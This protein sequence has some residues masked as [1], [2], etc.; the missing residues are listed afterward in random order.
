[1]KRILFILPALLCFA[2]LGNAQ[3]LN[4]ISTGQTGTSGTNWSTS[5]SN[6]VTIT[7]TGDANIHPD[8][9]SGYLNSGTSVIVQILTAT[10]GFLDQRDVINKTAGGDA[11]LTLRANRR[12]MANNAITSTSGKLNVVIWSDYNNTNDGGSSITG[13]ITTNGGHV[14][15]GGSSSNAGSATWNGLTVGN[16][17]S[18]G[19]TGANAFAFD[20]SGNVTTGGGDILIWTG[21]GVDGD[22]T[23]NGIGIKNNPHLNA[24]SGN[25]SLIA[26]KFQNWDS[27]NSTLQVSSTGTFTLA[28][29]SDAPWSSTFTWSTSTS[30]SNVTTSVLGQPLQI[31]NF[32]SLGGFQLGSYQG[33]GSAF[34]YINTSDITF[35]SSTTVSGPITAYGGNIAANQNITSTLSGAA[36]L[37]Q[38]TGTIDLASSKKVESNAGN[39]TFKSNSGGTASSSAAITLSSG[40]SV[41]SKGGNITL[42]G[43]STGAQGAGLYA[44]STQ[45]GILIES[46]TLSAAGGNIKLYGKNTTNYNNGIL[47]L[48]TINTTG[49]GTISL[50]G[51]AR[52]GYNSTSVEY[53][54]GV[55]FGVSSSSTIETENGT[56]TISGLL[57]EAQSTT[58]GAINFYR[59]SGGSGLAQNIISKTGAI[60][61]TG[62]VGATGANSFTLPSSGNVFFGS[63]SSGAWTATGNIVFNFDK[64]NSSAT[65]AF[66]VKSTGAVTYQPVGNSFAEAMTFP[67][68]SAYVIAESAS[69]LTIGK[70]SNTANITMAAATSVAGPITVYGG[71]IFA[72][73]NLT[74]TLSGTAILLQATGYINVSASRT[75][76]SNNGDITFRA[77]AGGTANTTTS[78]ITL[79]SGSSLLSKGGNIT[80][81]GNFTGTQG[82]GLYAASAKVG[83]S[84]AILISN[85]T[86]SA[87]GGNINIYGRCSTSYDDGIRLQANISTTGAGI[88]G[89]YG[90]AFGGNNGTEYFGG[91][92]FFNE[93]SRIEA[94]NGNVTL[95]GILTNSQSAEGYGI[96]FY[97]SGGAMGQTKHIQ[98]L[99]RT[100]NI[101]ITGDRG[102]S[103]G[104][105]IGHSSH[106]N[107]YF[108]SPSD[109]SYTASGD[110]KFT[111]SSLINAGYNGFK[112]K[113]TGDVTYEPVKASF[114]LAQIFPA[115]ANY[116]LAESASSLTIGKATNTA[117]ITMDA[118]TSVAGPITVFGGTIAVNENLNTTTGAALGDVLLKASGD[119]TLAGSKSIIT[120]GGDVILWS[121]S[122][123]TNG[124]TISLLSSASVQTGG[125]KIVLAGGADD[126]SNSG[127]SNDGIPDG[128][129]RG[130]GVA[131]ISTT[132]SFTLNSGAGNIVLRGSSNT[133]DGVLLSAST[134]G[135]ITTTG[136][137][138]D[139]NGF[140]DA[141]TVT[142]GQ[143]QSGIRTI[144]GGVITLDSGTGLINLVGNGPRHG[145]G[146]GITDAVA[147]DAATQTVIKSTNTTAN[148]IKIKGTV[149]AGGHG[150]SF[151][152]AS[153]KLHATG[154]L[155][156][157]TVDA[158]AVAWSTTIYSPIE[159][160]AVSGPINWLNSDATDGIYTQ[161]TSVSIALG[162]KAGVTG[163]TSSS[164]DINF[165]LKK[166]EG[167]PALAFGTTGKVKI[168]GV[169]GTASFGQAFNSS[170]FGLNANSQTMSG[171]TFGSPNNTQNLTF[172][173]AL[174]V[175]GPITAY[176]GL[177]AVD[178]NLN[179]T[180]GTTSGDILLKS[181]G[182]IA[183]A[184]SKSITTAGGDVILWSNSDNAA[185][186]GSI[187]LRNGS[188]ITTGSGTVAGGH[189]WL[190][191]GSDG[192]T[193]NGLAVG[194]GY[195]VPGT[196]FV[197]SNGGG[198]INGGIYLEGSS[199]NSFGGHVKLAGDA[200][201]STYGILA[202]STNS[203][204]SK[205]GKIDLDGNA[206]NAVSASSTGILFGIHDLSIAST[207]NLT[208]SASDVAI[209]ISGVGRGT[210][211]AVA[212]SGTL[213]VLS[214][215][216]GEISINGNAIGTGRSIVAGNYYSG[217]LNAFANSGKITLNGGTKAVQ[218]A[219]QEFAGKTSGPSKINIGQ[220]GEI[221]SSSSD[222]FITADNIA[223]AASGIAVNS[224]GK[225]T[226]ESSSN[227]FANALTFPIANLSLANTVS[228]LT[229]GK[230]TNTQNITIGG[231]TTIAGPITAYG[232]TIALN[233]NLTSTA[234]T[235]TGVSLDGQRIIQNVGIAVTTSGANIDYLASGFST[236]S[237]V[238]N[239]IKIGDVSGARAS[240]NAGGGNVSLTGSFGT[241]ST[242][243]QDD[244]GIYLFSTDVITSGTGSI[245]L[246]GDATNTLTTTTAYGMSMGNATLKTASG[247][248][249]LNGTGGK[250][251]NNSR[252]IVADQSSNKIVSASG[253]I[254]L[255]EI[256]PTG[257]T[258]TYTGFFM[259]PVSTANSFIGADGTE[260]SSS[261][262]SVTIKGDK[263]FFDV[264]ST[265]RNNINTSGAIVFESV[266]NS[267]ETA[268]SLTGLTISGNPSSVRVGKT[269]NTANITLGSAV[270]AAG[271]IEVYGGT[272]AVNAALTATNSNI[273]L[274]ASTAATQTAAIT[275]KGLALNGAGTFTLNNDANNI[276]TIAGGSAAAKIGSLSFV[277][278]SGGLEIGTVNP[279]GITATGPIKIETLEGNITLSENITTDDTSADA[280]ILNAGKNAAIGTATGGDII[281]SGNP[282]I[283]MG[284]GGIAKLFSGSDGA[285]TGL[286]T[287]VG[288]AN[289]RESVDET[290]AAFTP[291]LTSNNKYALYRQGDAGL[292]GL[293]I[294]NSGGAALNSG[295][296]FSNN[297]IKPTSG[298]AVSINASEINNYLASGPLTIRAGSITF[299]ANINSTTANS[300]SVLSNTFINNS[301][302]TSIT[303]QDGDVL[304]AT[305]VDDAT[306][307]ESTTN[308]TA[309][310]R[311][312]LT[313]TTNG[314]DITIGGENITGTG[315]ALGSS[316]EHYTEGIRIDGTVNINSSGGNIVMRGKSYARAV[317]ELYGASGLGFYF[318]NSAGNINSGSG[319]INLDGY[320]QT[321]GSSYSSGIIVFTNNAAF[322][323]T[324]QSANQ[325]AD[326]I[327][328]SGKATGTTGEAFG[329]ETEPT[330]I[331]NVL[332]T[333]TGG[334]I[335]LNTGN[336]IA[337]GNE[338]VFRGTT[339]IL[340]KSGPI[341]ILG[342]Q[343]GAASTGII[344][345]ES[346]L[347]LGS[348]AVTSI[349]TSTSNV[350][351]QF[352][353][354]QW[355]IANGIRPFIG[356]TGAFEL[357]SLGTS[358]SQGVSSSFFKYGENNQLLSGLTIGRTTNTANITFDEALTVAGPVNGNGGTV[359]V[360]SNLTSTLAAA[361]ILM[362]ATAGISTAANVNITTNKGDLILWSDSDNTSGGAISIGDNNVINTTN[363]LTTS[364]LTGGGKIVLAG[365]LDNGANEGTAN[366][367]IPDGFA[368]NSTN[369]GINL[370]TTKSN[371][372][373]MYSGGGDIIVRANSTASGTVTAVGLFQWG[374]WLAN[375]GQGAIDI[376]G[377]AVSFY[378][379]NFTE[380]VSNVTTGDMHLQL[381]SA[382]TSGTAISINGTST[383]LYG[384]VFNYNN[385]KEI[386]ATGG[387]DIIVN[388]TGGGIYQGIFLQ[389]QDILASAGAITMNAG[390]TG[391]SFN[392]A[393]TRIGSKTGSTIASSTANVKF[394]ANA[395]SPNV[396]SVNTTGTFTFEPFGDSFT[397]ALTYPISNITLGNTISG[398]TLGKASNTANITFGSATTIAGPITA[399]GGDLTVSSALT[400]TGTNAPILLK[401]T[402]HNIV[403][404]SITSNG[405]DIT[406]WSDSENNGTGG[407]RVNDNVS[408][409]SR[410]STDRTASTNTT[411]G[412]KITLAGGLDDA[413]IASGLSTLTSGLVA[414]DGYPDGYAVNSGSTVTETGIALGTSTS[415]TGHNAN[416]NMLS[417]GGNIRLHALVTKINTNSG[418]TGLLAFHGVN[419]NAGTTGDVVMIG[420]S[421]AGT[422][423][424]GMD[425]AAWRE[426]SYT[427]SS[428]VRT[429]NGNIS[430]IGRASNG[431]SENI[432][433]AI[434]GDG[435]KRNIFAATGSGNIT[436]NGLATGAGARDIRMT[437]SDV[438]S[439]SGTITLN[440][441]GTSGIAFGGYNIGDGLFIGQKAG[442]LVTTS[443]SNITL[444]SN[445][446]VRNKPITINTSGNLIYEPFGT[447]FSSAVN[448]PLTSFTLG[449]VGGIT[450]GKPGN[451]SDINIASLVPTSR[452]TRFFGANLAL[453]G[454][455]D[456]PNSNLVLDASSTLTQTQSLKV[457]GLGL[458][459]TGSA[460]LTNPGN[461]IG[462]IAGGSAAVPTGA[463][464]L[465][466]NGQLSVGSVNPTGITSSGLIELE[467]LSGDLL[468]T[469]PIV[470]TL[471]TGDAVRLYA[472]KDAAVGAAGDGNIKI[473]GNG[474]VTIESG[475]RAL[476][477]SGSVA[478]STGLSDLVTEANMRTNVAA[479]TAEA[480]ITPAITSTGKYALYR[481]ANLA[482]LGG[483]TIVASGGSNENAGWSYSAGTIKPTSGTAVSINASA[484]VAK[485]GSANLTVEG[486]SIDINANVV[487][488]TANSLTFTANKITQNEGISV[489]TQAGNINYTITNGAF[490][491]GTD[492]ILKLGT[493]VTSPR[494]II[495]ANGGNVTI[496]SAFGSTGVA[497]GTDRAIMIYNTDILTTG[498]GTISILGDATNNTTTGNNWGIQM[499]NPRIQTQLG[500]ITLT[501]I[502]GKAGS[503]RGIAVDSYS[504]K[505][506]SLS[507]DI[508]INDLKPV[509]STGTY[510]GLY[511]G[512]TTSNLIYFG[513]DGT[514]VISSTSKITINAEKLGL[515][516]NRFRTT[517]DFII[518]SSGDSFEGNIDLGSTNLFSSN[519]SFV[520]IGKTTNTA[521]VTIGTA[522]SV[523][524]PISIYGGTLAINAALT[525]TNSNII[526]GATTAITQTAALTANGLALTGSGSATLTN[527][528]NSINTI[529]GGSSSAKIG[530]L[531]YLN[532]KAFTVGSVN[533]TG[534]YSTGLIE[535]ATSTGDLLIT[536]PIVSTLA[537]GDAVKL[538]ADKDAAAGAAGDGNIIISGNG[539]VTIESGARAL[540][541]SGSAASST[542]L[543]TLV[544]EANTRTNVDATTAEAMIA[545]AITSTGKYALYREASAQLDNA[546]L[547]SL[548]VGA[549]T[550]SPV[551]ETNETD[552][553]VLLPAGTTSFSFTPTLSEGT[554]SIKINGTTHT[555]G[556]AFTN[557]IAGQSK[558]FTIQVTSGDN[559]VVKT[560][561]V[562]VVVPSATDALAVVGQSITEDAGYVRFIVTGKAAQKVSLE[563]ANITAKGLGIDYGA[564]ATA[565]SLG[566]ANLEVSIDLGATWTVFNNFTTIPASKLLWV[567]TPLNDDS[568]IESE[569]KF[570]LI[571]SPVSDA[572]EGMEVYDIGY[573]LVNLNFPTTTISGTAKTV[574]AVYRQ[575]NAVT[576]G[577]QALDAHMKILGITNVTSSTYVVDNNGSNV[578]RFQSELNA[579]VSAGSYIEYELKFYKSGTTTQVGV[580]NFFVTA[581]DVDGKEYIE[582]NNF[583]SYQVGTG[584][585]LTISNPR[586]GFTRYTGATTSLSGIAFDETASFILNYTNPIASLVFRK[587]NSVAS[588]TARLFSMA[589]GNSIGNFSSS[590]S[591]ESTSSVSAEGVIIDNDFPAPTQLTI[592]APQLT[593]VKDYSGT[594]TAVVVPG[595]I[596]GIKT[597]DVVTLNAT[598]TYETVA[599]GTAKKI[600]VVYTLSGADAGDYLAPVNF[601]VN[602][603]VIN[604]LNIIVTPTSG[605]TK[606]YGAADPTLTYTHTGALTGETAA[607][608]GT[609][610]RVTGNNVGDYEILIGS[611]ALVDNGSFKT[612]NYTLSL[613]EDVMMSITKAT[614][615]VT[616]KDDSKFVSTADLSGY[617]GI[618]YSGFV[619]GET[620]SVVNET[621]L[622]FSRTNSG[623][624]APGD[625]A[626]VLNASGLV[627]SNYSFN[628][629]KG[630]YT[631][632]A[633]DQLLVKIK[634]QEVVYGQAVLY[635]IAS[636]KY[637]SSAE[638]EI[639]DLT[640]NAS[641]NN[642]KITIT[643]GAGGVAKFDL[644]AISP[645]YSSS[646]RLEVGSYVLGATNIV[647]TSVNFNE[648]IVVQGNLTITPLE[649]FASVKEGLSKV[650]DGTSQM[651]DLELAL[652]TPY[653]GDFVTVSGIGTFGNQNVGVQTYSIGQMSLSGDDALNYYV[654]GG[655]SA[656]LSGTNGEITKRAIV[657]TPESDQG[658]IYAAID[659]VLLYDYSGNVAGQIPS[660]SGLL[661]REVGE[662][663][664]MYEIEPGSI[665]LVDNGT[666]LA[667]N[668]EIVFIEEKLFNIN[669]KS[670]SSNDITVSPVP[671]QIYNGE[672]QMPKPVV[673]DGTDVLT[674][675]QDYTLSYSE[676]IEAGTATITITGI[677]DYSGTRTVTFKISPAELLVTPD[678]GLTKVYGSVDPVL[679][680]TFS[681]NI[682]GQ[683][684]AFGGALTRETGQDVSMY[685]I[686]QGSLVLLDNASFKASNYKLVVS[687]GVDMEISKATIT[688]TVNND[689]KF[690]TR[691]DVT[692]F[693]GVN[694][695][696][697][698]FGETASVIDVSALEITRSNA[699]IE[700]AG[701]YE[702]VLIGSGLSSTNYTFN[703]LPGDFV[704]VAA[705]QLLVK[706]QDISVVYGQLINYQVASAEYLSS[707]S[708]S[709]VNLTANSTVYDGKVTITDGVGGK[710]LFDLAVLEPN[711]S[712]TSR[713]EVGAYK[714]DATNI[715]ETSPNFSN[716]IVVQGSLSITPK[717]LVASVVDG[718]TKE[719]DGHLQM[720]D[721][722]LD[723]ATPYEGDVLDVKAKGVFDSESVGS[724]YYTVSDMVLSGVDAVNY[725]VQG[726]ATA[727]LDGFNAEITRRK[728]VLTP[729]SDQSKLFGASDP[730]LTY[731]YSGN[732]IGSIPRFTGVL[733]RDTGE[734]Q[735]EYDI[736]LGSISII[737]NDSFIAANYEL[738][739]TEDVVFTIRKKD[740]SSNDFTV[741]A[742]PDVIYNGQLRLP[743]PTVMD[744]LKTLVK[745]QDFK[746]FYSENKDAG[747][748]TITIAG[749]ND[750]S[751]SRTVTFLINPA[752]LT[753]VPNTGFTKIYGDSDPDFSYSYAG[754]IAGETPGF[755]G[756]LSR[757]TGE[758]AGLYELNQGSLILV[759]NAPF[760]AS[761][762]VLD[763]S[764]GVQMRITRAPL[765]VQVNSDSKFVTKA[766][767]NGY[768]G[769]SFEGFKFGED[770][771][772]LDFANLKITRINEG[773]E[774][775]STYLDVLS[776]SGIASGNYAFTY[777]P[778]DY[779][780]IAAEELR[781]K[782]ANIQTVYGEPATYSIESASYVAPDNTLVDLTSSA[783]ILNGR[784]SI[785]DGASGTATF[786]LALISPVLSTAGKLAVGSYNLGGINIT[787][788]STNFSNTIVV[789]GVHTVIPKELTVSITSSKTKV[790][791]GNSKL[792][793]LELALASPYTNDLVSV[794]GTGT[795]A[796]ANAGVQSY[797]VSG[798][799][800]SG[801][802]A[803]NYFINGGAA[804][805]VQGTNGEITKR[806]L[807]I[808]PQSNQ[809]KIYGTSDPILNFNYSGNV[810]GEIPNF[811][812]TLGRDIG[813]AQ[814]L[815]EIR[816]GTLKPLN[817]ANFQIGNY[818]VL[819]T[820]KIYF[821]ITRKNISS[822]EISLSQV[823]DRTYNGESQTPKPIIKDGDKVLVEGIDY[824]L[825][826][827]DN[828]DA[829][830][831]TIVIKGK[832][833][834][835]GERSITFEIKPKVL[836]IIPDAGLSKVYGSSDP[837]LTYTYS[838]NV[839]GE[840]P[841]FT[842]RLSRASGENADL[843]EINLGS[844]NTVDNGSF[845]IGNYLINIVSDVNMTINRANLVVKVNNDSKFI[846]KPDIKDY[847]GIRYEGFQ[848]G[849]NRSVIDETNLRITRTNEGVELAQVYE[850]VLSASGVAS[851][852]YSFTYQNGD[853]TIVGAQQLLVKIANVESTYGD[854]PT[855]AIASAEYLLSEGA[856]PDVIDLRSS[857]TVTGRKVVVT[858]GASGT[859]EFDIA[860]LDPIFSTAGKLSVR[861]Y[862]LNANN[863]TQTSPNFSNTIVLQGIHSLSPKALTASVTSLKSKVYDG[864]D[865]MPNLQLAL[866][867]PFTEDQVTVSG[868]GV[869]TSKNAGPQS[870][871]VSGMALSGD[872][873]GNYYV[874]GGASALIQGTDGLINKR[875]ITITPDSQQ[876]KIFGNLDP[877]LTFKY[878]GNLISETPK[879]GGLLGRETGESKADY[880][881]QIGT[882]T[883]ANNGSFLALNYEY[884]FTPEVLFNIDEKSIASIDITVGT[885]PSK[886]YNGLAQTP[887]PVIKDGVQTLVEG[888]DYTLSYSANIE[889]GTVTISI[890]GIGG[891]SGTRTI[892]FDITKAPLVVTADA[893]S[894][895]FGASDPA[896]TA[897]ITG[898][899][900][901]EDQTALTG[902]LGFTRVQGENVGTYTITPSGLSAANY[903]ISYETALLSILTKGLSLSD[904]TAAPIA[905]VIYKGLA[906]ELEPILKDG[907]KTL[908]KDTDYTLSYLNNINAGTASVIITA[909]GNYSGTKTIEFVIRKAPLKVIADNK[910]KIIGGIDP[911]LTVSYT[912]FVNSETISALSGTLVIAREIGEELGTYTITPSGL[913]AANYAISFEL[914]SF[915]IGD[916]VAPTVL[917]KKF[918]LYLDA[919]GKVILNAADVDNGSSDL[920][921]I[922]SMSVA[923]SEFTCA[924][925]GENTV[926]LTVK[927]KSGNE[928]SMSTTVTVVDNIAPTV[929]TRTVR[930]ALDAAG[931]ASIT[932]AQ[933]NDGSFDN[934][935]IQSITLDQT[936]FNCAHVGSQ[937]LTLTVTDVNGNVSSGTA[938]VIVENNAP[939]TD[940]DGLKNNCDEDDDNDGIS[941][942]DEIKNGTDPLNADSDGDGV[943]DGQELRDGTNPNDLCSFKIA[944]QTLT[945][946]AAW[947][948]ADCDGDGVT[949]GKERADGTSSL[950][951]CDF[952]VA[953]RTLTPSD[954]WK[955][956][957]CDGD[958]LKNEVDGIEDCDNDG[959]PNFQDSD[960]CK[961]DI[962]MANVFTPNG[963]GI[964]DEIKPVLL[965]IDRF[966][967]FKV[968]N[969]WGNL[970]F[971]TNDREK[972]WDGTFKTKGQGTETFQW[973]VEGYDRDGK[974]IRRTGMITLLR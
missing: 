915:S 633:A 101:Q 19:A 855:Y 889:T 171:F 894:K 405:G 960:T 263:A 662:N 21:R 930:I 376:N 515:A 699:S 302:A 362:K 162:S 77:N 630:D 492:W 902:T 31:N 706:I 358:F 827:T 24:G 240:I 940:R 64:L 410:T 179:T 309:Q 119:I 717:E 822:S 59:N 784:V 793:A 593:K 650:Y 432:A 576:I 919:S 399:Y 141:G 716:T 852:N 961:I 666:F 337:N 543:S 683:T 898:Y 397:N 364:N 136:G 220:G 888:I 840:I 148:A 255:N 269:T 386:L 733:V 201:T 330:S 250:A 361:P 664:G 678:S 552:Y 89:L 826:Y 29:D 496:N 524:G 714:I 863:I 788:T 146:F 732:V 931:Q 622:V 54:G 792:P 219:L 823:I 195:A 242:A 343:D 878:V 880:E 50:F 941:D 616:V 131:G 523:A 887:K 544:T 32:S 755:E 491:T 469:E 635:E 767:V 420:N 120:A 276:A 600:T 468:I 65:N 663:Q 270:T 412:G 557:N 221:T 810:N 268:P 206:S 78:A 671:D 875:I 534:I 454:A 615:T 602:D 536:E 946:N 830:T 14:W 787:K 765:V 971:E 779:T 147:S 585:S 659:P 342:G 848:F 687:E 328:I 127:T 747:I 473:S 93:V 945:P 547:A 4:I 289:V 914:G 799:V 627:A 815:Y 27:A 142:S 41:L 565:T 207:M 944:S 426:A 387:G 658:K 407:I 896:F 350:T 853:F 306:D 774:A 55:S 153:T 581:V 698:V 135:N 832:G 110:V 739:F 103:I 363:G 63:P 292:G 753:V 196:T 327:K 892:T 452:P 53:F 925:I 646:S 208:S 512:G 518:Q 493:S 697:F 905:D 874:S 400:S 161:P 775:A 811:G 794:S 511:F 619:Y 693:A 229:L 760:K 667:N 586:A 25:V 591:T 380:P 421:T 489:T 182:D 449:S 906:Y 802:D 502:G 688:V 660:F 837:E 829:G 60:T 434:D 532:N 247:T 211:D 401:A 881:I 194:S 475:A 772:A 354:F 23:R 355:D 956:G 768:A 879:F 928:S 885:I 918:I 761:N 964:N 900:N 104:R 485:L 180:T 381:I 870:Y 285:S 1:M 483:I 97:R 526:L 972:G 933:V 653:T 820:E 973:L 393:G 49:V 531:N 189:V 107:I 463:L 916:N 249:T 429:V 816:L 222:V 441:G 624:E 105:G 750:Y 217:I 359:A 786:D 579:T 897:V 6:P 264:N 246:T 728:L 448:W 38:A 550:L 262:S 150:I 231:A 234:T 373:Q 631:I 424:I 266:A 100:G 744:G 851:G 113:T 907:A 111:Y 456:I 508:T 805:L 712:T 444:I 351:V 937:T 16:G 847:A 563:M 168:Q 797:S 22:A 67:E 298:T 651:N 332:A 98:I 339:S 629:I 457:A 202:Y 954:A 882:L 527:A 558:T 952:K 237:G 632:V 598:A 533:P 574:G 548:T 377:K 121:D 568:I 44:Q 181:S 721:L 814:G 395:I 866:A 711:Y 520:Q 812:G 791:D 433:M 922:A 535:L 324:I 69:S 214:T 156:G 138:I 939:D 497:G 304:F 439:G 42:G 177:I 346:P 868:R 571:V 700:A 751:G 84:P 488:T 614:L 281:V 353:L 958:G 482:D 801:N 411:G 611:L 159:I 869:F 864:S 936:S 517:G 891:F 599:A 425:L 607:F 173:Q 259:K 943:N 465:V 271:P 577:G 720:S 225:V 644:N 769:L 546:N 48:G 727:M 241:T 510:N 942:L 158:T 516:Y 261:S 431:T 303:T 618:T 695:D 703:Y 924:N 374:K 451:L 75:I 553:A 777:L 737:D 236:T 825:I 736:N 672:A 661:S 685:E 282:T 186:N 715:I 808:T 807:L 11:T 968:Y 238:D 274:T 460:V 52:G 74:S 297:T 134:T 334:G 30:G 200:S 34:T 275:A 773:I 604:P 435:T 61:I 626:D 588:S 163:L 947:A 192:A 921:G 783:S 648:T 440:A 657:L 446:L 244:F 803:A 782:I 949:N 389:N 277:D 267:F 87:A 288:T 554:A 674:E 911:A 831:S 592:T 385:P 336:K 974:L 642:G 704:I 904:I 610:A 886:V 406:L 474:T 582:L 764:S 191:G 404:A 901:S 167:T 272:I 419:M 776:A 647:E 307:N 842:G 216:A 95:E 551:F 640:A 856:N 12:A 560:Y 844:L 176:G 394:I 735:G 197:P 955:N 365:G 909:K 174:T 513:A 155:G 649:L 226:L 125:G 505:I 76:E 884:D 461:I 265:F 322:P 102:T 144:G 684:P 890:R 634:D 809:T 621:A 422:Y 528:S 494:A 18:V 771:S 316:A 770:E 243:G 679:S 556:T 36:I 344:R 668:Y 541:Y 471:A 415:G 86:L 392:S 133:K 128:Y 329:I 617:G 834:Y 382:K 79:N 538:Y 313:I 506:L 7:A 157:I 352:D 766:D 641:N 205:A 872:D 124:G 790:Y 80:L 447:S 233:S 628:Y 390:A 846:T 360:N 726:G 317:Q 453:T 860:E 438:L 594:N 117:N 818:S 213:N 479:T 754:Q 821:E 203:I 590:I 418:P 193:W 290:S 734:N 562:A 503:V 254:T 310:F 348:R 639:V 224:T 555:S 169:D 293:T 10:G 871:T 130:G 472:D 323:L 318:L 248:I 613:V 623:V 670:I 707:S 789:Q 230:S 20:L 963:D 198:T 530:A 140:V 730:E 899:V 83:G 578:S 51:E 58:A 70:A 340:A 166:L 927:D 908:A 253:A 284:S 948:N 437:N 45:E 895:V 396:T 212:L 537:T 575:T 957:D 368:S 477:Y 738:V 608:T 903:A 865:L 379:I 326:A 965:G 462:T 66:K 295:W 484:I 929:I 170:T 427:A 798:M 785:V 91:I 372:T 366:D 835:S 88:I 357:L 665:A 800:L 139:I 108:G 689:S 209:N 445:A 391:F 966:V 763:I 570:K 375:S 319:T 645:T 605:L 676:N 369:V 126:G 781:V 416:I 861:T 175:A 383:N 587:G 745:D 414:A 486:S 81:G 152:G 260:V 286:T 164:S 204:D 723:L 849:E 504:T 227:S 325:T 743:E 333:G 311:F 540:M 9:I 677:G 620:K 824:E 934:C 859:A 178:Q 759:D 335:T 709:I 806:E 962:F 932:T 215:G 436:F 39:I 742:I 455:I 118:S 137:N 920:G 96:N 612:S 573:N 62:D 596:T 315:Y 235:G 514:N 85:A 370:G 669:Q 46:A 569:E 129:A 652:A 935:A 384:V 151:R 549:G 545:P 114:D 94:V 708:N 636:A 28:S 680:Y 501:G 694:Y 877:I 459:G 68:H 637:L 498:S 796:S 564:P 519:P 256:K 371:F 741:E 748:A 417:G 710:A 145:L 450:V 566:T 190:G 402:N 160:L 388:G 572:L 912:G 72:Q 245:T 17:A 223:L 239:A 876:A 26:A 850:G 675:G 490:T 228:G 273:N 950:D 692:L 185:S 291:A 841:G 813:E 347:Y 188:S 938:T 926:V 522:A 495:N 33:M 403:S 838:G 752:Q 729:D 858:D 725:Y 458:S 819:F 299:D 583:S 795:F 691:P 561:T 969:R 609:L 953:S 507:G 862:V 705:D 280:I 338:L 589:F 109:N 409:D 183:L 257:L 740:I 331:L 804:A 701:E 356:S 529:A 828:K 5:G 172:N 210:G 893:K 92:T 218:V 601:V 780:I 35:G 82:A 283:T 312:G 345:L 2:F 500:A 970:I 470:S 115:N 702:G 57:T 466:N 478:L 845:K 682:Q 56:I 252:G 15:A 305:N 839:A 499:N 443:S 321:T 625:Y 467:T 154:A 8:V 480:M 559:T 584:S 951:S 165:N 314:G 464:S 279:T 719:Y 187:S 910:T 758:N 597:G 116:V 606:V 643:D 857:T 123:V 112:V 99:S 476:M 655:A 843:Y 867:T 722:E 873:A 654:S 836:L 40:S 349:P 232:G 833:D 656:A 320:S 184:A 525:A 923:P 638:A 595:T 199:I 132:G 681:G 883:L 341:E 90:D 149:G 3:N 696:G 442:S 690:V 778:G 122:D 71:N 251:S 854:V 481:E 47:F 756:V 746:Y 749:I 967:C 408:L 423:S 13:A 539:A 757:T 37:L 724:R 428:T 367:G 287:L 487:G 300:F 430:V 278:A 413:G 143:I 294:V 917:V 296:E 521:N 43:G 673:N 567:R 603:G 718:L 913:N 509:G 258:G 301:S 762:Y 308:G 959:I 580:K 686:L 378:G 106:G 398:L 731:T 713:L 542:G 73:Q 817:N